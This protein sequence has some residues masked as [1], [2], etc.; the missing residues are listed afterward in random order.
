MYLISLNIVILNR[1]FSVEEGNR[2]FFPIEQLGTRK[3]NWKYRQIIFFIA[4][5]K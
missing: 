3:L 5:L 2:N 1:R 4:E